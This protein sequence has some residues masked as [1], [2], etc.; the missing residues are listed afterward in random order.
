[1]NPSN[2][3]SLRF[4][5]A[6]LFRL[7]LWTALASSII[8]LGVAG[9]GISKV[10][11]G[12]V[13]RSAEETAVDM[14]KSIS[15]LKR[16]LLLDLHADGSATVAVD[17]GEYDELDATMVQ[18]MDPYDIVKIKVFSREGTI[19]FSSERSL[20]GQD[21]ST[22]P[23]LQIALS[24]R[25]D[26]AMKLKD[27]IADLKNETRLGI[28][29]VETYVPVY[30]SRGTIAG[31]FEIYQ[32]MTPHRAAVQLGVKRSLGILAGILVLVF[33]LA[34]LI[35]K[36]A[37]KELALAQDRLHKL[38]TQDV[39]TGL[40]NRGEIMLCVSQEAARIKRARE[41]TQSSHFSLIMADVDKFK[42]INDTYGHPVGDV[43][44]QKVAS[45]MKEHVREY[46]RVGRYGGEEFLVLLPGTDFEGAKISAERIRKAL[47][48]EPVITEKGEIKVTISLGIA[49]VN[50]QNDDVEKALKRADEA[51]YMAKEAGRN[52]VCWL[53]DEG[54]D[55]AAA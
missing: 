19:V 38:A 16:D 39:L 43:V 7:L 20:I 41:E 31:A 23:R 52:R 28:D 3:Q 40:A 18:V 46:D 15:G 54:G 22:N 45:I 36:K 42:A 12:Y 6:K 44:L 27:K 13:I 30:D 8:I 10:F 51:L 24:G 9:F 25:S 2:P 47:D 29:L 55:R 11:E 17:P 1:M 48:V 32:D 26:S 53:P 14:A 49:T 21:N 5:P 50:P 4:G 35:V 33:G 34:S 37:A